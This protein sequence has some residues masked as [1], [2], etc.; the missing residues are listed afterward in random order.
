MKLSEA[1]EG[2]NCVVIAIDGDDITMQAMRFGIDAGT[3]VFIQKNIKGGP[4]VVCKNQLEI[5]IGRDIATS[6]EV[7]VGGR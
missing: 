7:S 4:V 5:A 2:Q 1:K 6:I 3:K